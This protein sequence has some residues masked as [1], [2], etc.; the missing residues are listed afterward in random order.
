MTVGFGLPHV[1]FAIISRL[2]DRCPHIRAIVAGVLA[3]SVSDYPD[4][5]DEMEWVIRSS[6]IPLEEEINL[7]VRAMWSDGNRVTQKSIARLLN[8]VGTDSAWIE[9]GRLDLDS[10]FPT[11]DW[12]LEVRKSGRIYLSLYGHGSSRVLP[13][14]D[15]PSVELHTVGCQCDH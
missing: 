3:G 13:E 12:L 11:P 8:Y 14:R 9:L 4:K 7:H 15:V 1:S 2:Y 5:A 6:R 10:L